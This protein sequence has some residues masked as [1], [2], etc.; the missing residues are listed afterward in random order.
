M[1]RAHQRIAKT[2]IFCKESDFFSVQILHNLVLS[3]SLLEKVIS[4]RVLE[5]YASLQIQNISADKETSDP[6]AN[7]YTDAQ[8]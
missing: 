7:T 5:R 2:W 1:R 8:K 6:E 3:H 4:A